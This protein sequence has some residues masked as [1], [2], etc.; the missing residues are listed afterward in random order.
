MERGSVKWFDGRKGFGFV[1]REDGSE[2]FVHINNING[3]QILQEKDEV[4]FEVGPGKK[5][6]QALNLKVVKLASMQ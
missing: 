6:Q 1:S 4:E 2:I 5:G 3:G